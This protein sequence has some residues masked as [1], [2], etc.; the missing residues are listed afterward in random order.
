MS[1]ERRCRIQQSIPK[2]NSNL[3]VIHCILLVGLVVFMLAH[4]F[5]VVLLI[6]VCI[7]SAAINDG[8]SPNVVIDNN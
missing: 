5:F 2:D 3:N 1:I 7:V 8:C 4:G 6:F